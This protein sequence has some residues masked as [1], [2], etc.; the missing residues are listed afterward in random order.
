MVMKFRDYAEFFVRSLFLAIFGE[1]YGKMAAW[2]RI[3]A[4]ILHHRR[5]EEY[6]YRLLK[7]IIECRM[8]NR[9]E[10]IHY[11][12][13]LAVGLILGFGL[14]PVDGLTVVGVRVIAI[15]VPTLYLWLTTNTHWTCFMILGLLAVTQAMTPNE[16]WANSMGHFIFTTVLVYMLFN[17]CLTDTGV[18]NKIAKF[19]ITR[20]FVKGRPY[21]FMGMFFLSHLVVGFF[22]D[23]VSLSA[24]YIGI[25]EEIARNL[26]IKKGDPMYTALMLG[27]LWANA[28]ANICSPITH[29]LPNLIIS[30]LETSCGITVTYA[31]WMGIGSIYA[32]ITFAVMMVIMKIWNPDCSPF[33]NFDLEGMKKD[34]K[35]L[36][37]SGKIAALVFGIV[38]FF[39]IF[40]SLLVNVAPFFAYLSGLGVV[41]PAL[42]G[43]IALCLIPVGGKPIMDLPATMKKLNFPLVLFAGTVACLAVPIGAENT[44]I[45]VWLGNVLNPLLSGVSPTFMVIIMVVLALAMTN[46]LSNT[47][48]G[49]LFFSMGSILLSTTNYNMAAFAIIISISSGMSTIT[50]SASV[51]SPFFFGPGH[52]TVKNT[53]KPN[54]AF[55]IA[56]FVIITCITLPLANVML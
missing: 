5:K 13:A 55:V 37:L 56:T 29:A 28:L 34:D 22:V 20:N 26:K 8:A 53:L 49:A 46:F 51:P 54:L 44:G 7:I 17:I 12:I 18:I 21:A 25:G 48:T 40:P 27:I 32:A 15:T 41:I 30:L 50:P 47:V 14:Q 19:F 24:I 16:V 11:A 31:Q 3:F 35:P 6:D 45:T 10:Y 1:I 2:M 33:Q 52:L 42:A 38:V 9:K 4:C 23:S 39:V 43:I 36:D